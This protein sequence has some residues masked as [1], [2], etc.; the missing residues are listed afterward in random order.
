MEARSTACR[1]N[2][3]CTSGVMAAAASVL[4]TVS[5]N[6]I[7]P[8]PGCLLSNSRRVPE[9]AC[10]RLPGGSGLDQGLRS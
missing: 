5:G 9:F 4:S 7:V 2:R 10:G 6:G 8:A 1:T 3:V